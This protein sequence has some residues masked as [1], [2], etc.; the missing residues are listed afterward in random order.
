MN[1]REF[2][3]YSKKN[4]PDLD[5]HTLQSEVNIILE[6]Y[7]NLSYTDLFL[8]RNKEI[9]Y[10]NLEVLKEAVYKR[11]QGIPLQYILG[12]WSFMGMDLLVGEGV[13]IPRED[14]MAV[15]DL[16]MN[17]KNFREKSNII[18]ICSGSGCISLSIEKF[19]KNNSNIY[20]LEYSSDA[21]CY[22]KKNIKKENSSV[23]PIFGDLYEKYKDFE[24]N[25][26]DLILSNPPYI[27]T[28]EIE[29]LEK[30]ISF[31]P[32]V[33]LDGGLDGLHFYR[34]ICKLW[35]P[36]LKIGGSLVFEIG[37][38]QFE[39]VK[40][41]MENSGYSSIEFKKDINGIIRA[42]IGTKNV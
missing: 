19:L 36:K 27:K 9:S 42:I 33:A 34:G 37:K 25:F 14:T 18:D 24:N 30:E 38:D 2:Y 8:N 12:H 35:T 22:L 6:N 31:E 28:N 21:F 13:L 10:E 41:I 40:K 15:I 32:R 39:D 20:A 11:S 3:E 23:K 26:F 4:L 7:L 29:T 1:I 5:D 17:C 16:A